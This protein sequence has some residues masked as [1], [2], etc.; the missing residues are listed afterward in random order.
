M[1]SISRTSR[2]NAKACFPA[3]ENEGKNLEG[4]PKAFAL[5]SFSMFWWSWL[6]TSHLSMEVPLGSEGP[7][8]VG[9]I[10]TKRLPPALLRVKPTQKR[11]TRQPPSGYVSEALPNVAS[12]QG[13]HPQLSVHIG[14]M[15]RPWGKTPLVIRQNKEMTL[16]LK[17]RK[18]KHLPQNTWFLKGFTFDPRLKPKPWIWYRALRHAWAQT[19]D[20]LGWWGGQ[21]IGSVWTTKQPLR[22]QTPP[23]MVQETLK[24]TPVYTFWREMF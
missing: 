1:R 5:C 2:A 8:G 20:S 6:V 14:L 21:S 24:I 18:R 19:C 17:T 22:V 3:C 9:K 16:V 10:P 7:N 4:I 13:L 15:L 23:E 12:L 11:Q